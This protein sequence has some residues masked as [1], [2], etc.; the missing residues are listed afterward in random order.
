MKQLQLITPS[1]IPSKKNVYLGLFL[2]VFRILIVIVIVV[3]FTILY[4]AVPLLVGVSVTIVLIFL[5]MPLV[6]F[7]GLSSTEDCECK[8]LGYIAL[9]IFYPVIGAFFALVAMLIITLYPYARNKYHHG[10]YDPVDT[11]ISY[12]AAFYLQVV[13]TI[14]MCCCV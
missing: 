9:V 5:F 7:Y 6:L 10:I 14:I 13:N 12:M 11:L 2:F 3:P 1:D 8:W 4:C